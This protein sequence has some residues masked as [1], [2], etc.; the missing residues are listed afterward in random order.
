MQFR[1]QSATRGS[2][3][4]RLVAVL[5]FAASSL[6]FLFDPGVDHSEHP[7]ES[8]HRGIDHRLLRPSEATLVPGS[9]S[10]VSLPLG[11]RRS[12][13][14]FADVCPSSSNNHGSAHSRALGVVHGDLLICDLPS[15]EP[16][17][18]SDDGPS[19]DTPRTR[20][21]AVS[22]TITFTEGVDVGHPGAGPPSL[23]GPGHP[24]LD[25][26]RAPSPEDTYPPPGAEG[27]WRQQNGLH[28]WHP[29][30]P[31]PESSPSQPV[32]DP[33]TSSQTLPL[34]N[35]PRL[36]NSALPPAAEQA[37]IKAY[38]AWSAEQEG[39]GFLSFSEWKEKYFDALRDKS[40][41]EGDKSR[42]KSKKG[43][44]AKDH[45]QPAA[46][47]GGPST[48]SASPASAEDA[49]SSA[50][51]G[52]DD[53][54]TRPAATQD[55]PARHLPQDEAR[56]SAGAS[57]AAPN[58][59]TP[60]A[61]AHTATAATSSPPSA[62]G[63]AQSQTLKPSKDG[64]A[65]AEGSKDAVVDPI[66][67]GIA[68]ADASTQLAALKHRWNFASF[69][70]AAVVHRTNPSAKFASAILSEKKDRYMLSPC[71]KQ[72]GAHSGE[73]Q[74][75]IIEL[76]DVI[77][78]DTIVLAN[79]EFFSSMF[80]KFRVTAA[81]QLKGRE[82][83]WKELGTFRARNV[84]GL[85]VFNLPPS[86]AR[87]GFYRYIRIDF[88]EHY[89]S[90][91][92]CPVSLLRVYGLTQLD[93]YNRELEEMDKLSRN[94]AEA[95]DEE[96]DDLEDELQDPSGKDAAPPAEGSSQ[97]AAAE[98]LESTSL[99]EVKMRDEDVWSRHEKLF[100]ERLKHHRGPAANATSTASASQ[101]ELLEEAALP[102]PANASGGSDGHGSSVERPEATQ[103]LSAT[104][105]A[106]SQSVHLDEAAASP[107][108]ATSKAA[109]KSSRGRTQHPAPSDVDRQSRL[110]SASAN[111][112]RRQDA[113]KAHAKSPSTGATGPAPPPP[114]STASSTGGSESIYRAIT[115]RL[116]ALEAN[117]TLSQSYI[118]HSGQMLREVFARMEKRQ[119]E[120]M[121][122]ML[123]SLNASNWRQ[124]EAL[125]RRQQVDLQR[126]I[127][128]FDVH[129]QQAEVERVALMG[130]V[131]ALAN[132]VLLE[133][134]LGIA[135]LVLLFLLFIFMGLTR[136]SRAAPFIHSSI[137]K[138]SGT[139]KTRS[140]LTARPE[141]ALARS[142]EG[143]A[144]SERAPGSAQVTS[145][146]H[147]APTHATQPQAQ[148]DIVRASKS[149]Q[150]APS[151]RRSSVDTS[152]SLTAKPDSPNNA[153]SRQRSGS[154]ARSIVGIERPVPLGTSLLLAS[155]YRSRPMRQGKGAL[156]PP[157][158]KQRQQRAEAKLM[159]QITVLSDL[160][161]AA[162]HRQ[163]PSS[164]SGPASVAVNSCSELPQINTNLPDAD[165]AR[166]ATTA[167]GL[168]APSVLSAAAAP[169]S[170]AP[171]DPMTV[172]ARGQERA[173]L[174]A[175]SM[176]RHY[177]RSTPEAQYQTP[178]KSHTTRQG[179]ILAKL[180]NDEAAAGLSSDWT[181]KSE[182]QLGL[183][184]DEDDDAHSL[185]EVGI[186]QSSLTRSP[187][188][189][190]PDNTTSVIRAPG[191]APSLSSPA[192]VTTP[193]P[194]LPRLQAAPSQ[195]PR[196]DGPPTSPRPG[197]PAARPQP[198]LTTTELGS[199]RDS[200]SSF[201]PLTATTTTMTT[202]HFPQAADSESDSDGGA[203]QRVLPRRSASN[204][205][206]KRSR[207]S[208]PESGVKAA[209]ATSHFGHH[210]A[211]NGDGSGNPSASA[212]SSSSAS[213][214]RRWATS[215]TRFA[216]DRE[217]P[218]KAL[219]PEPPKKEP[220]RRNSAVVASSSSSYYRS[221][222]PDTIR[223][224]VRS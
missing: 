40:R 17:I 217:R 99:D 220:F 224:Q 143:P 57:A 119:D 120:R 71:P 77:V 152:T 141:G 92:Y 186:V 180:A 23:N 157:S 109:A 195:G 154:T 167:N 128:E 14:F 222:T 160:L 75:V 202:R 33:S 112:D 170:N 190:A 96:E 125:K 165:L 181:E 201:S 177:R 118:E 38:D 102:P 18:T 73:G 87:G 213:F 93:D 3:S 15:P 31:D 100:R 207:V 28:E 123:R 89:G 146:S 117:A 131:D 223:E 88:L 97:G 6:A 13:D 86:P 204:S 139:S 103:N 94:D 184:D 142:M 4:V 164:Q 198:K 59:P 110:P 151:R 215:S 196:R 74:F 46:D 192:A 107:L 153:I 5:L 147:D 10:S 216:Q 50:P 183:S 70:C 29:S 173:R 150:G 194:Q 111:I 156:N 166:R 148:K 133:K 172:H 78:I 72:G 60:A 203:W 191:M 168:G 108:P 42:P 68:G 209:A 205:L 91:F 83:D 130:Q 54:L 149:L 132:E 52:T 210:A 187:V 126:A 30:M 43:R 140:S 105:D 169:L 82:D 189:D 84:R 80:K 20:S 7:A 200:Q 11:C 55:P 45:T 34:S 25:D 66:A 115:R 1:W 219:T 113:S 16:L 176:D 127:F 188:A 136:G 56:A 129:R 8:T 67:R 19:G 218:R 62:D 63:P 104:E 36:P 22:G 162:Q 44:K 211:H 48:P 214:M 101:G 138:I 95:E 76:C 158:R 24:S 137:A 41:A 64:N 221:G 163:T 206:S 171:R 26:G 32:S 81:N 212:S 135:Q 65:I 37:Q 144:I 193:V 208:T 85:Q 12:T 61:G 174:L 27:F 49:A 179:R 47:H 182:D 21:I 114:P 79:Y 2:Y 51:A 98:A 145:K 35:Q 161:N 9:S 90:E 199:P 122:D 178:I 121:T 39:Q 134:R 116:N 106:G 124:I 185:G 58:S 159:R 155:P 197:A 53:P 175:S 69:D